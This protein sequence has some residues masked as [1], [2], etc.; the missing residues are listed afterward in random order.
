MELSQELIDNR[1]EGAEYINENIP[2]YQENDAKITDRFLDE[3]NTYM[4]D[5]IQEMFFKT[6]NE[7]CAPLDF[8]Y[9]EEK[10]EIHK[11]TDDDP[12]YYYYQ[13][14]PEKHPELYSM[15]SIEFYENEGLFYLIK[16]QE[17]A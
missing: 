11:R 16:I 17:V 15:L 5:D 12:G 2:F 1:D 4:K 7:E 9:D 8:K 6:Y 10:V 14:S 13:I 3:L